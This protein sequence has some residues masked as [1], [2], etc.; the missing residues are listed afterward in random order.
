MKKFFKYWLPVLLWA[1]LIF[2]L[3]STSSEGIPDIFSGQDIIAHT[4]V[5]I[6]LALLLSNAIKNSS[7]YSSSKFKSLILVV[8]LSI[9]YAFTDEFH[10]SFVPG[11]DCSVIDFF[12]DS[13]GVIFGGLIYRW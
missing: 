11:R 10:Q 13:V 1:G 3:S 5:Y 8:V 6:I 9:I 4:F 12:A 2:F 7:R